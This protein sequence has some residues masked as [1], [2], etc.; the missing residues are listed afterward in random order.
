MAQTV[1]GIFDKASEAQDAVEALVSGGFSR[2]QI[3]LSTRSSDYTYDQGA[4]TTTSADG[5]RDEGGIGGF[6]RSLFGD[7][8]DE[9]T[10]RYATVGERGSIVTVHAS[11]DDLAERA[12]DILD[13]YGAVDIDER[14]SQ[15]G[16]NTAGYAEAGSTNAYGMMGTAAMNTDMTTTTTGV[17]QEGETLSVPIIEENLQ[18]GK[19]TVQTGGVRVRSRIVERPVEEHLRLR[20]E[21]VTVQRNPVDRVATEADFNT[22]REGEVEL[23]EHAERAVVA[24]EARVVEEVTVGKQVDERDEVIRDTVRRTDVDVEQVNPTLHTSTT[25]TSDTYMPDTRNV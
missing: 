1:V 18:V 20:S 24:K 25:N 13:E 12:A 15:Y 22:F 23:T 14:A 10:N 5:S 8:D 21:R 19:Q 6:F 9:R 16:Y 2:D 11:T 3:D 7:D 4:T 17:V